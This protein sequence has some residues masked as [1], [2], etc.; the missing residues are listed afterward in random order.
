VVYVLCAVREQHQE[1]KGLR[2]ELKRR[3]N[4]L[5]NGVECRS[6]GK[7]LLMGKLFP[8]YVKEVS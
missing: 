3:Q 4:M 6:R 1:K 7:G 2:G 5:L 8:T